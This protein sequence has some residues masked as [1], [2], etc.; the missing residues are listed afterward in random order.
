MATK[1]W[2]EVRY[3]L[4]MPR[5]LNL[6]ASVLLAVVLNTLPLQAQGA[7][8]DVGSFSLF[9]NGT[10]V[11]R[12]Q[13]SMQRMQSQE[14]GVLELRAESA[15]GDR[16]TAM[17]LEADSAGTPVRYSFEERAGAELLARLGGRRVRGRFA[18]LAR[19]AL[20]EAA[21]E[22]LLVAGALVLEDNGV[23]QYALLIRNR[24]ASGPDTVRVPVLSLG[25]N[26][27]GIVRLARETQRDTV[28][29]AGTRREATRWSF[30][31]LSGESRTVWA[32]ADGRILRV[33][34]ASRGFEAVRDDVPS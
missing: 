29:V 26:Q 17:R 20:G 24:Q 10:R 23:S 22:Y 7:R 16:R 18:T 21:H 4:Q 19:S 34:I 5:A 2:P 11:G 25:N 27:Q 33:R 8:L 28:M 1:H 13:F 32:D 31:S 9:L 15:T 6:V 30:V 12:E 14:G 3:L